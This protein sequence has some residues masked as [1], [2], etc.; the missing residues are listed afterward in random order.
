M[1]EEVY[2]ENTQTEVYAGLKEQEVEYRETRNQVSEN[3]KSKEGSACSNRPRYAAVVRVPHHSLAFDIAS[4][5]SL[6]SA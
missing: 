3:E 1:R 5:T 6:L 2:D 4:A